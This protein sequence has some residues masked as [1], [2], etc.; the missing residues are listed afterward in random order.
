MVIPKGPG[1]Q[2]IIA[3]GV[4]SGLLSASCIDLHTQ[5][6]DPLLGCSGDRAGD[7][8]L[9]NVDP[10]GGCVSRSAD[11]SEPESV[12]RGSGSDPRCG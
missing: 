11:S 3:I 12:R 10:V 4:T 5:L 2:S 8:Q 7:F 6:L 1:R 9:F